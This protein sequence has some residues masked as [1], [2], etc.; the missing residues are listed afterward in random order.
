MLVWGFTAAI[1]HGVLQIGGWDRPWD[2]SR[3]E[4]LPPEVIDLAAR[5]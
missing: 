4:D 2:Q 3:I 5:E 1:L